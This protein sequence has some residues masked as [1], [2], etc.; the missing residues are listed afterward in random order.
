LNKYRL[1]DITLLVQITIKVEQ[2]QEQPGP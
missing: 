2:S 1:Q